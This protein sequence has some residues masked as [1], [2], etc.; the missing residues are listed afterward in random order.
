[1]KML[2]FR[3]NDE[4]ITNLRIKIS[5][6]VNLAIILIQNSILMFRNIFKKRQKEQVMILQVNGEKIKKI[7][8]KQLLSISRQKEA[9]NL[10]NKVMERYDSFYEQFQ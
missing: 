6:T 7:E 1:M 9:L 4:N 3:E 8:N 5:N 10:L 2:K